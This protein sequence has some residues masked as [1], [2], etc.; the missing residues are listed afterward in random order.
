MKIHIHQVGNIRIAE[1]ISDEVVIN[2][3]QDS[4]DLLGNLYF[5]DVSRVIIHRSNLAAAFFDLKNGMAGDILQKFSNYRVRLAIEGDFSE[6]KSKSLHDFIY[7][8]NRGR[9]VCFVGSSEEA[10][11]KLSN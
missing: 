10:F 11:K 7:E 1:I 8:C 5:Q 3:T 2:S 9:Q 4:I 6:F